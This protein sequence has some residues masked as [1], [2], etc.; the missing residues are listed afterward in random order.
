[1]GYY[2]ILKS[3]FRATLPKSIRRMTWDRR[4]PFYRVLDPLKHLLQRHAKHDEV[5]DRSYYEETVEPSIL[6]S[7]PI[8]AR[9][10]LEVFGPKS[11]VDV[12]CGTGA[13]LAAL[14]D[15]GIPGIGLEYSKAA[16]GMARSKGLEVGSID[17]ERPLQHLPVH[18]ADLVVSTEVAEH[19]PEPFA[20]TYVDYLC[21]TADTTLITAAIPGQGGTDHV[22]EQPNEY[23]VGMFA[24]RGFAYLGCRR[25]GR[26][27]WAAAGVADFYAKNLLI[28]RKLPERPR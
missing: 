4:Y 17:L 7:A 20:E 6:R 11:V 16:L 3:A 21:Q 18:R 1:M 12:G 25:D 22:N 2:A 5:Y 27:E 15:I 13:L 10:V 23:W 9:S 8:M 24:A 28:F 26:G 19:L 14:R